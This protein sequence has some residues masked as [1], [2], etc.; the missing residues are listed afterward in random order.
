MSL[1]LRLSLALALVLALPVAGSAATPKKKSAA[2][3]EAAAKP[4]DRDYTGAIVID[5]ADGKVLFEDGADVNA[6]PASVTKLMNLLLCVEAIESGKARLSDQIAVT[7]E[8]SKMGGSQVFLKEGEVFSFEDMLY[9]MMVQSANDAALACANHIGGSREAFVAAMNARAAQLGMGHTKFVTPHGLASPKQEA[10]VSTPR[11]IAALS[12]EVIRHGLALKFTAT[13]QRTF[14]QEPLLVMNN[15][16]KLLFQMPG[17][18]GLKTGYLARGGYALSATVFRDGKRVIAV[19][20]GSKGVYGRQRDAVAR[21]LI[22][23]TLPKASP[24]PANMAPQ[25]PEPEMAI[26]VGAGEPATLPAEE[27]EEESAG[28]QSQQ[29]E[30][31]KVEFRL[32]GAKPAGK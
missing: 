26:P 11:D 27:G 6:F 30:E 18:D 31:P 4:A 9:A 8:E 5:A 23:E 20:M 19:V 1:F 22:A 14:R 28:E 24:L 13:K 12:R 16:N 32:P 2:P 17:C 15:H 25:E 10:D 29:G 21:R 7:A 3:A